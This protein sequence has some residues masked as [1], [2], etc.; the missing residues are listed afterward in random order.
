MNRVTGVLEEYLANQKVPD[1]SNGPWLVGGKM[2]YADL[3]FINWQ[4]AAEAVFNRQGFNADEYPYVK[5][6]L[7]RMMSIEAVKRGLGKSET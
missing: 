6:W 2:S 4:V 1:G 5:A 3:A 7:G